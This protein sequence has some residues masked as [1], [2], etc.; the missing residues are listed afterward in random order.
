MTYGVRARKRPPLTMRLI[1]R[2]SVVVFI[3]IGTA[4]AYVWQRN[5]MISLG[6]RIHELRKNIKAAGDEELKRQAALAKL[7]RPDRLWEEVIARQLGLQK[8]S[9]R[10]VMELATPRP[11]SEPSIKPM[12]AHYPPAVPGTVAKVSITAPHRERS[13]L[14]RER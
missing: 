5:T 4:V 6:Y 14:R 1:A 2:W 12:R 9:P 13:V 3:V 7:R 10:Q 8:I 11:F